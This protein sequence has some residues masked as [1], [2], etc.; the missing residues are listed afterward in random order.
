MLSLERALSPPRS[1][2][3]VL[4]RD[5]P[6]AVCDRPSPLCV[7]GGI[8]VSGALRVAHYRLPVAG[9]VCISNPRLSSGD[10]GLEEPSIQVGFPWKTQGTLLLKCN[11]GRNLE[12][13]GPY[14]W[15]SP[16]KHLPSALVQ[17]LFSLT[18]VQTMGRVF[19]LKR[20]S[21]TAGRA[22]RLDGYGT[23]GVECRVKRENPGYRQGG[24]S[25]LPRQFSTLPRS[26]GLMLIH[27]K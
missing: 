21:R 9:S 11:R 18:A 3:V 17:L 22:G 14:G 13:V 5:N 27:W 2:R 19:L 7:A 4:Y 1:A 25:G 23:A 6:L 24:S 10:A 12:K 8:F 16:L 15:P 20:P 26:G